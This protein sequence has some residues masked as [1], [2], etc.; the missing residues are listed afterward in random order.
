MDSIERT[1]EL[2]LAEKQRE[3]MKKIIIGVIKWCIQDQHTTD[4]GAD[5][6]AWVFDEC[7]EEGWQNFLNT[8]GECDPDVSFDTASLIKDEI[9]RYCMEHKKDIV[10]KKQSTWF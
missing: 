7:E 9:I 4:Y 5:Y 1:P 3:K 10:Y 6:I 2:Y 8:L